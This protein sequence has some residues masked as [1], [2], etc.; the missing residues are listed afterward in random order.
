M[1]EVNEVTF[2]A[3]CSQGF[4]GTSN[5]NIVSSD[6][7]R[8]TFRVN[9]PFIPI[10]N[11]YAVWFRSVTPLV[12]ADTCYYSETVLRGDVGQEFIAQC[13]NGF[14][15]VS[16]YGG[17]N[18]QETY[19]NQLGVENDV[20]DANCQDPV[21]LPEFNPQKRCYWELN[22]P[23]CI[24]NNR[25]L[26]SSET[27][28]SDGVND[29]EANES[30]ST[31]NSFRDESV[32]AMDGAESKTPIENAEVA[33]SA[34]GLTQ[35]CA[36]ESKWVDVHSVGVDQCSVGIF[37]VFDE[38]PVVIE[39]QDGD[40]VSFSIK[41]VWKGFETRFDQVDDRRDETTIS[42][43]AADYEDPDGNLR[44]SGY[45]NVPFGNVATL[46]AQCNNGWAIVDLYARQ[47][48]LF[49]QQDG[50]DVLVP[51]A[52][53]GSMDGANMCHFRYVLKCSPSRCQPGQADMGGRPS[54]NNQ[55]KSRQ[56]HSMSYAGLF[57]ESLKRFFFGW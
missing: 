35:D 12:S 30:E 49:S 51:T 46:R 44:C 18:S 22:V 8:V 29:M 57:L 21:D 55:A 6:G 36:E 4:Y 20:P 53:D 32:N 2:G 1:C 43:L 41:Q 5:I 26:Q 48:N 9:Q 54:G 28:D 52:C 3:Q 24:V 56:T 11:K 34:Q 7:S 42:W 37:G 50:S 13:E 15:R 16:I 23:C 47:K 10:L 25:A 27:R 31:S 39:S 45:T 40:T 33:V 19:Y 14:A 38:N 17:L